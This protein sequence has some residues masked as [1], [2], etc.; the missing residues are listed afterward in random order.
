ME[1]DVRH[2][3]T[4]STTVFA[5]CYMRGDKWSP[6]QEIS[7]AQAL[8]MLRKGYVR[9]FRGRGEVRYQSADGRTLL[10]LESVRP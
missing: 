7:R 8:A 3:V 4:D 5:A 1:N 9:F 6:W 10:T 2:P